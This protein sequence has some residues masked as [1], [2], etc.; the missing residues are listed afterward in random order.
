M[1]FQI[2]NTES[3]PFP[4]VAPSAR[5][6][7]RALWSGCREVRAS[8]PENSLGALVWALYLNRRQHSP[9][10]PRFK[11]SWS[12][13][14]KP[15]ERL[16]IHELRVPAASARKFTLAYCMQHTDPHCWLDRVDCRPISNFSAQDQPPTIDG[17]FTA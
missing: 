2:I 11:C 10:N 14:F 7:H 9:A 15:A 3:A 4:P 8:F 6:D 16:P 13:D 1:T 5:G 17:P 12:H